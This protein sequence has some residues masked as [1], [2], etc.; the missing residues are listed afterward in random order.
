MDQCRR[1]QVAEGIG[2]LETAVDGQGVGWSK[3]QIAESELGQS[4]SEKAF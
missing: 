4:S 2:N 1:W 3:E